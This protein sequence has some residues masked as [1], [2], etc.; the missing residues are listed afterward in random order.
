MPH[1]LNWR[2][3]LGPTSRALTLCGLLLATNIG[4][5]F[6]ARAGAFAAGAIGAGA[7]Y[8]ALA[9]WVIRRIAACA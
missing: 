6:A 1:P 3:R 4:W 8:L 7:I 9:G 5:T 2:R